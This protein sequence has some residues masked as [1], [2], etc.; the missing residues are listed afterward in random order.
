MA[1][2][3][4]NISD[5]VIIPCECRERFLPLDRAEGRALARRGVRLAGLSDLVPPYEIGRRCPGYHVVI[6]TVAGGGRFWT[7]SGTGTFAP[8]TVWLAPLRSP[9]RYV[10]DAG[11]W[12]ILWFHV[13][14]EKAAVHP[15][16]HRLTAVRQRPAATLPAL[17]RAVEGFLGEAGEG[18]GRTGTGAVGEA[19]LEL[20]GA[21]LDRELEASAEDGSR[22][23]AARWR[24]R[25]AAL[26]EKV[27]ASLDRDWSVEAMAAELHVSPVHFHRLLRET[28]G[29]RP[30]EMLTRLRMRQAKGLLRSTDW[31]LETIAARVGYRTPFSFSRAFSRYAGASPKAF[32]AG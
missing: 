25:L 26:W 23:G 24:P 27:G 5:T 28:G 7:A 3:I 15:L 30:L 31:P 10:A 18:A 32:R 12:R 13:A 29:V 22:G 21:L 4:K 9:H 16:L 6:F 17:V 14:A 19:Y 11:G 1:E 2:W 20:A 8:G